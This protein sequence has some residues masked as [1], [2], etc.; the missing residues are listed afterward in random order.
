MKKRV[1]IILARGYEGCGV[2]TNAIQM[3]QFL[4]ATVYHTTDKKWP[5]EKHHDFKSN[6]WKCGNLQ[7][8]LQLAETINKNFDL[9]IL[10]SI[11]SL[12]H[13]KDCQDNFLEFLK[14]ITIQKSLMNVDHKIQSIKRNANLI[15]TCNLVD[16]IMTHSLRNAFSTFMKEQ[17]VS[18]PLVKMQ[19]GYDYDKCRKEFWKPIEEQSKLPTIRW[20]GRSTAWKGPQ[21][22]ID[23]HEEQMLNEGF[24][25]I[26]EGLEASIGY[27]DIIYRK[28][29]TRRN[30]QSFFRPETEYGDIK[31]NP[32]YYGKEALNKGAYLYPPYNHDE[33]M[34]RMSLSMFGSDLYNLKAEFY[35]NNIE[36]CLSE[37]VGCGTVPVF[38]KHFGDNIV[39][40]KLGVVPTEYKQSGTVWLDQT[41]FQE[42]KEL[43]V[44][45]SKDDGMRDDWREMAFE[46]WKSHSNIKDVAN[47][48]V[49]LSFTKPEIKKSI[50]EF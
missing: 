28:D 21:L 8:T 35:G 34:E 46:F 47:E 25:T 17:E 41:N 2:T 11:P 4:D 36:Y 30:V 26:L 19:V 49:E 18:T 23:F 32:A 27:K 42:T 10:F 7:E 9:V 16:V 14:A 45:L 44:K 31:F 24:I 43:L 37:P 3:S 20:I 12:A 50:I 38:H 5:R 13:P 39:H 1:A 33:C 48:I 40:T 22:L 15:E 6:G 29:G